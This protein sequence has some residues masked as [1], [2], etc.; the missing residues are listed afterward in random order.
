MSTAELIAKA[1][2]QVRDFYDSIRNTERGFAH[3]DT[4]TNV[5]VRETVTICLTDDAQSSSAEVC[6]DRESGDFVSATFTP[7]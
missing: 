1:R 7:P 2:E 4:L 3:P 6:L 5:R